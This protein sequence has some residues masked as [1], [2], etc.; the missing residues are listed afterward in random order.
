MYEKAIINSDTT[1]DSTKGRTGDRHQ[2]KRAQLS[3]RLNNG[4]ASSVNYNDRAHGLRLQ[5]S[6]INGNLYVLLERV[7]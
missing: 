3:T 2:Q 7:T 6:P 4:I 5:C 1:S